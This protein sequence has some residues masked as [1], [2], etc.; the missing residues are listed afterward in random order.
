MLVSVAICTWNRSS[1]LSQTLARMCELQV[2]AR[3]DWELLVVDNNSTDDT[4]DVIAQY[5]SRLPI[6]RV[7]EPRPGISNARNRAVAEARGDPLVFTDDDVLVD[8]GWLESYVGAFHRWPDA[9]FFGGPIVPWFESEPPALIRANADALRGPFASLDLGSVERAFVAK[10]TPYG[11]NMAFRKSSFAERAFDPNLGVSPGSA[12]R[13]EETEYC[14][15]LA[16]G[17]I[18]GVWVP[19]ASVRHFVVKKRFTL[20]FLRDYFEGG[21]RTQVRIEGPDHGALLLG[22]PRWLYRRYAT[23]R[24]RALWQRIRRRQEWLQ[25]DLAAA[26]TRGAIVENRAHQRELS[27]RSS[28][29]P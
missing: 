24:L 25:T 16:R 15:A 26:R 22:A 13:N 29:E 28:N 4:A 2:P 17:G 9:G 23:L 21:G 20:A 6:R 7:F 19:S 8:C 5:K 3:L 1:L 10:E 27:A 18:A 14:L 12:I 11:A